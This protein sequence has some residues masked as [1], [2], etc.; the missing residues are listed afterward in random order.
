MTKPS[1]QMGFTPTEITPPAQANKPAAAEARDRLSITRDRL[2]I[3]RDRLIDAISALIAPLGYEVVHL[4]VQT[5]RQKLLRLFIDR[6]SGAEAIGVEDCVTVSRA[7]D[8][9]LDQMSEIEAIFHGAYELEVSSPGVDRPLR[10][11]KDFER[12]S[13]RE[14]RIHVFRPLTADET[15]NP[16][17]LSRNPR[18]KN[19]L[20][21]LKGIQ[22][23]KVLLVLCNQSPGK[24]KKKGKAAKRAE[25]PQNGAEAG[26]R[27]SIPLPLISKAN[28]EPNFDLLQMDE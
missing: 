15:G 8:E 24:E 19:F 26:E 1:E 11:E 12:F 25:A 21:V 7:L 27:L 10:Q 5:H 4:E 14:V 18:Q 28:L 17:Y 6:V 23:G 22:N 2:S 9:P 3:T 13:G 20:G 16:E